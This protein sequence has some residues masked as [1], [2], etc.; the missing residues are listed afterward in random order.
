MIS[1][2]DELLY[3]LV[4]DVYN[5]LFNLCLLKVKNTYIY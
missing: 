1:I 3:F 5:S 2:T 4:Q